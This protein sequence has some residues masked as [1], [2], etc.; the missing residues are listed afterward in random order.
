MTARK[1]QIESLRMNIS[2]EFKMRY[3]FKGGRFTP[4]D[5]VREYVSIL[6]RLEGRKA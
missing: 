2:H 6:R 5:N 4:L 1:S 3:H